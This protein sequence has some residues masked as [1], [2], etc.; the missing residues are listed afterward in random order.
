VIRTG[1]VTPSLREEAQAV[2]ADAT[3]A[4]ELAP[5]EPHYH[6]IR[7]RALVALGTPFLTSKPPENPTRPTSTP[8]SGGA[9]PTTTTVP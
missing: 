7:G 5:G 8:C 3:R 4:V 9:R 6:E 1:Q 2:V